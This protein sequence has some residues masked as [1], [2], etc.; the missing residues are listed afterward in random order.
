MSRNVIILDAYSGECGGAVEVVTYGDHDADDG[1][2]L[3]I[4]EVIYMTT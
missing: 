4:Q 3:V 2:Q 1:L